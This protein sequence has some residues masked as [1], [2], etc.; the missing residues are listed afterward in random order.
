MKTHLMVENPGEVEMTMKITMKVRDWEKL[1]EQLAN[2]WP[3]WDLSRNITDLLGQA[4]KIFYP[5]QPEE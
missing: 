3:A 5:T 2:D 4:R 1:R